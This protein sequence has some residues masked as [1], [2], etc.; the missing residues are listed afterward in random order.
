MLFF[1]F[2]GE[3]K[4]GVSTLHTH[5]VPRATFHLAQG[6]ESNEEGRSLTWWIPFLVSLSPVP[7]RQFLDQLARG[8]PQEDE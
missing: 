2:P 6:K 8:E 3:K 1:S 7:Y 4:M 5:V